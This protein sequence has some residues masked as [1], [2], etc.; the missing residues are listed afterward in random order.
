[1]K[2]RKFNESLESGHATL[3]FLI[4]A[5]ETKN[6]NF[7][8]NT[9]DYYGFTEEDLEQDFTFR[10]SD[11]RKIVGGYY[12]SKWTEG[13]VFIFN[14]DEDV[15]VAVFQIYELS[16]VFDFDDIICMHG[17]E[18]IILYNRSNGTFKARHTR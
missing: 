9:P 4:N 12:I 2:I 8:D 7:I 1:M 3:G 17:H 14:N 13:L 18:E 16:G 15:P 10:D 5:T 11:V 6:M